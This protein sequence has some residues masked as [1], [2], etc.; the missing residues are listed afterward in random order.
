MT[1]TMQM[2][3]RI[4]R[5]YQQLRYFKDWINKWMAYCPKWCN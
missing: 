5:T 1:I 2:I 4:N 3:L